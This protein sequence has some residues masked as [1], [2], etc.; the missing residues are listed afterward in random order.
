MTASPPRRRLRCCST[1][2]SRRRWR[3]P[4][5][6]PRPRWDAPLARFFKTLGPAVGGS[7]G[8]QIALFADTI[9]ASLLPTGAVAS[10]YFADRLYQ[11]PVGVIG[12]AAGTVLLPEMSRRIAGGDVAGAHRAQNRAFGLTLALATPFAVAFVILPDLIMAALF[13]RGAFDLAAADRAGA[14]LAAYAV[15]LP[16]VVLIRSAVASFYARADTTTPVIATF[17]AIAVNVALKILLTERL[18]VAGLALGTAAG[19]W[20]NLI[21]L[22]TLAYRRDWTVPDRTLGRTL[23]AVAI[24]ALPLVAVALLAPEPLRAVVAGLPAWREEARL[25]LIGLLGAA[26]YGAVLLL[27]LKLLRVRLARS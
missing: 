25:A 20:V 4:C 12:I 24:A 3:L 23:A 16:A 13:G 15:G 22:L 27:A 10:L 17:V 8:V 2:R 21:L 26:V 19:A 9:I 1:F 14:A 11:L 7:A 6:S 5:S 18:G